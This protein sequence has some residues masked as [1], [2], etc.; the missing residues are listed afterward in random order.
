MNNPKKTSL[1]NNKSLLFTCHIS[2]VTHSDGIFINWSVCCVA[3]QSEAALQ[4][5]DCDHIP[6]ARCGVLRDCL[7]EL[8]PQLQPCLQWSLLCLHQPSS[9]Q[10]LMYVSVVLLSHSPDSGHPNVC[11]LL[12]AFVQSLWIDWFWGWRHSLFTV[13]WRAFNTVHAHYYKTGWQVYML[14]S[15]L[16]KYGTTI[17]RNL[18]TL[19]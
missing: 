2:W 1:L 6:A 17:T 11:K 5:G 16:N 15:C 18:L 4:R 13:Y 8:R 7:C 9:A 3:V 12:C 14:G 19:F 10:K